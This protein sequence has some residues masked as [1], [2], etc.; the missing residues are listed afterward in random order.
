MARQLPIL[1]DKHK[2]CIICEGSEEYDYLTKLKELE[3]WNNIYE[4]DLVNADGNGNIPARY[5]DRYQ[6]GSYELVLVFCDTEKKPYEQYS[7][8]KRKI[9]EFHGLD[10][11]ADEVIIFSNPCTMEI[12]I[13]HWCNET[14]KTAAKKINAPLIKKYTGVDNYA[15]KKKQRSAIMELINTENYNK[16]YKTVDKMKTIDTMSGSTN[17]GKFLKYF[18]ADDCKWINEINTNITLDE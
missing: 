8:I 5:Q 16:M 10:N 12:I 1:N 17:F 15:G 2:I 18:S 14:L 7:D 9:N 6:N 11:A 3:V 13:K 4:F